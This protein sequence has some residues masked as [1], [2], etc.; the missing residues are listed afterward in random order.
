MIDERDETRREP[1]IDALSLEPDVVSEVAIRSAHHVHARNRRRRPAVDGAEATGEARGLGRRVR[2]DAH[3]ITEA[4]SRFRHEGIISCRART[5]DRYSPRRAR[6]GQAE[7]VA[8]QSTQEVL[9]QIV[10]EFA[11][12]LDLGSGDELNK[13]YA[14][15]GRDRL[16]ML[17]AA[18][19]A[20][21]KTALAEFLVRER[22]LSRDGYQA[23]I[24]GLPARLGLQAPNESRRHNCRSVFAA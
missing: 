18:L 5:A 1:R 15:W 3:T 23:W 10:E 12:F 17:V 14:T 16:R 13:E 4:D 22:D 2:D 9:M 24:A 20:D 6:I 7:R 11:A 21:G 8:S 19:P